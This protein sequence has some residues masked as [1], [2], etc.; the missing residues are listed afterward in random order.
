MLWPSPRLFLRSTMIPIPKGGRSSSSNSDHFRSIAISSILSK[1]LDYIIINQQTH[2]LI[3][4]DHQFGFKPYSSTVFCTTMLIETVQ[5]YDENGRQPVYV[6]QLDAPMAFD[7]VSYSRLFNV[8]LDKN[9]CP[10]IVRLLCYMCLHPNYCVKWNSKSS[11]DFC[12]SNRVKQ[13]AVISLILFSSNMDALFE[14]LKRNA[15]GCHV[16]LVY[17][18]A[19]GYADDVALVAPSYTV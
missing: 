7:R 10:Y 3:T 15:I 6:L 13:G 5:Y 4:S 11:T 16:G 12:A 9:V 1:I 8:L 2:S 18:G 17:A 19:F 14:R